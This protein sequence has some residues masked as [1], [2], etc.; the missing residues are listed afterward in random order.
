[1]A[2]NKTKRKVKEAGD[3]KVNVDAKFKNGKLQTPAIQD[4]AAPAAKS[5]K[6]QNK[7]KITAQMFIE[8]IPEKVLKTL[9]VDATKT[10]ITISNK[11]KK[12]LVYLRDKRINYLSC[13]YRG[14]KDG[15]VRI[16]NQEQC[17][18]IAKDF[19]ATLKSK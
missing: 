18:K 5:S 15:A 4:P 10:P 7:N 6:K 17:A 1:M 16:T 8:Q 12:V 14:L 11:D 9:T 19:V 13:W 2:Y 3:T